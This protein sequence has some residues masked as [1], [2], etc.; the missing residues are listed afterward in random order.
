MTNFSAHQNSHISKS[1]SSINQTHIYISSTY[2]SSTYSSFHP[3]KTPNPQTH[4]NPRP[5]HHVTFHREFPFPSPSLFQKR[6]HTPYRERFN[7]DIQKLVTQRVRSTPK[8]STTTIDIF[9]SRAKLSVGSRWD[10]AWRVLASRGCFPRVAGGRG[11]EVMGERESTRVMGG[12][13]RVGG[14]T[15]FLGGGGM[16]IEISRA[17]S[18]IQVT[19]WYFMVL[20][21]LP[22]LSID[23]VGGW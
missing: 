9:R 2:S 7:H 23:R 17:S 6:P 8:I 19:R 11:R 13:D 1:T 10:F 14:M 15:M 21:G 16:D 4:P 20:V 22:G 5:R 18:A 12:R 3:D